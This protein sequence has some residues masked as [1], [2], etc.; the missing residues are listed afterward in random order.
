MNLAHG[1]KM[2]HEG[3]VFILVLWISFGLVVLSL[4]FANSMSFELKAADNRL[5]MKQAD[6][7]INGAA[8]YA[9]YVI[10]T[11]ATN[12]VV[13]DRQ[14]YR[15]E[16]VPAGEASFWFVG[17]LNEEQLRSEM[18]P[19]F[20]LVDEAS[21]LNLNTA[22]VEMLQGLPGMTVEFAAAIIDWRDT[23]EEL[24][25]NGAEDE[26]YQRLDPPRRC[27]NG[28]FESV[29]ELRLVYGATLEV[30][31]GEDINRNGILDPNENDGDVSLPLD[32]ADGRLDAGIVSYLTVHSR[33]LNTKP[34]GSAK[35]NVTSRQQLEELLE[36][37]FGSERATQIMGSLGPGGQFNSLL[38]FYARSG[39]TAEEF[40]QVEA[41]LTVSD[42]NAV[43]GLVNVNTASEVVLSC[44]PGIGEAKA[45]T[46]VAHRTSNPAQLTSVAWV[47]DV[48][49]TDT[50]NQAGRF[51]TGTTYQF[52]ADVVAVGRFNRGFCRTRFVF[53]ATGSTPRIVYRQDLSE[54]GWALGMQVRENLQREMES[55]L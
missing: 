5:A 25:E 53:D 4:Y 55:Q 38:Q 30:L 29:D 22:T 2:R 39:M 52:T 20:G 36:E 21:K 40:A 9:S 54:L 26:S 24:S 45:A 32:N 7:A 34:D 48:L 49:D 44:I 15:S 37:K 31:Y 33:Q 51:L 47:K 17:E 3:S 27:K 41:E 14:L 28:P 42:Q 12:G 18:I 19:A 8:R 10:T 43:Q 35:V 13:P 11:F 46:M 6:H 50:I 16:W 23:N 1:K